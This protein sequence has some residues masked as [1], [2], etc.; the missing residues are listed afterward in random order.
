MLDLKFTIR[1]LQFPIVSIILILTLFFLLLS[2]CKD[3]KLIPE[4]KLIKVYV[5]LLIMQDTT[6]AIPASIDSMKSIVFK[7]HNITS[8]EYEKKIAGYNTS[9]ERWEKFF[10]KAI[11][12][13]E[14][15]K[16]KH[17]Q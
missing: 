12:Y 7:R 1:N 17:G 16:A 3:E 2:S 4:E 10:D 5:D 11:T 15:L 14:G 9:P 6:T 13:A 8:D